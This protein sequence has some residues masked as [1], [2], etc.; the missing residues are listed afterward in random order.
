MGVNRFIK[1]IFVEAGG[2]IAGFLC[3]IIISDKNEKI[4]LRRGYDCKLAVL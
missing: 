2:G 3:L 1:Y 4:Q